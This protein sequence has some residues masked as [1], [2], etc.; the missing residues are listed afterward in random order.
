M[1]WNWW[2]RVEVFQAADQF[3]L[4]GPQRLPALAAHAAGAIEDVDE[5]VA[6]ADQAEE[7]GAGLAAFLGASEKPSP[8]KLL[9][10][11]SVFASAGFLRP[12]PWPRRLRGSAPAIEHAAMEIASD[13]ASTH[14]SGRSAASRMRSRKRSEQ[15][16]TGRY[17]FFIASSR[18]FCSG[19]RPCMTIALSSRAL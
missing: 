15:L 14:S 16:P 3:G 8:S 9:F 11:A 1:I 6:F 13:G 5:L 18:S 12:V 4:D 10:A 17:R 2:T 19:D 7:A